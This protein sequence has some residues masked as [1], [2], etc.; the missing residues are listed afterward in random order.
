MKFF[1]LNIPAFIVGLLVGLLYIYCNNPDIKT[2]VTYPSPFNAGKITYEDD[3]SNCFQYVATKQK[4]PDDK[5]KI[6][7][8]PISTSDE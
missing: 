2:I 6:K 3:A 8:Q 7:Q 4:C 5:T 1:A